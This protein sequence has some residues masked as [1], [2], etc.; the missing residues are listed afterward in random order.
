M[1]LALAGRPRVPAAGSVPRGAKA[2]LGL[3]IVSVYVRVRWLMWRGDIRAVL[4]RIRAHPAAAPATFEPGSLEARLVAVRL[5]GAVRQT[6]SILPTDSRCLVQS[7]VL[8]RL[9]SA[10]AI[11]STLVIGARP[12]PEFVA[13]A[14]VEH[15]GQPVLPP[16][17]F[18]ELRLV[19]M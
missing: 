16:R 12:E 5:G 13:H 17:G 4:S 11:Q 3:E 6:L 9:L 10:R 2:L 15:E 18:G 8:S 14:W 19:E 1:S 7:L